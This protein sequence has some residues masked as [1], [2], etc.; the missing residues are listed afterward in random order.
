MPKCNYVK[1]DFMGDRKA[2]KKRFSKKEKFNIL[3]IAEDLFSYEIPYANNLQLDKG[4]DDD[5]I[6][7]K[8]FSRDIYADTYVDENGKTSHDTISD[9]FTTKAFVINIMI[10]KYFNEGM[11]LNIIKNLYVP[12]GIPFDP[13][14]FYKD[15]AY[16]NCGGQ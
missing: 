8:R 1:Y 14:M 2:L 11:P 7:I 16:K 9:S 6:G 5:K 3:N 10:Q 15:G 4:N 12:F 13:K